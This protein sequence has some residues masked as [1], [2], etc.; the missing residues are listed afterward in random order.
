MSSDLWYAWPL[1][2][3]SDLYSRLAKGFYEAV[4]D[5]HDLTIHVRRRYQLTWKPYLVPSMLLVPHSTL[6]PGELSRRA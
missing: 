4:L 3:P 5:S 2:S 1:C 6:P